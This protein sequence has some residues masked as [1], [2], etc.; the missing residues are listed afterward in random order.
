MLFRSLVTTDKTAKFIVAH[1]GVEF[2][3]MLNINEYCQ[4]PLQKALKI[5]SYES[6]IACFSK[7]LAT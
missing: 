4:I 2:L 6:V 5:C 7:P 3:Y 1:Q